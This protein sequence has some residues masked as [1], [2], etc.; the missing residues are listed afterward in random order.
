MIYRL[1]SGLLRP[2]SSEE[3]ESSAA[4]SFILYMALSRILSLPSRKTRTLTAGRRDIQAST[5]PPFLSFLII[6]TSIIKM[7]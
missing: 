7:E 4:K 5:S 6:C 1:A 3:S 2:S